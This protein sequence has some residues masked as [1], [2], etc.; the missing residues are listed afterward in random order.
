MDKARFDLITRLEADRSSRVITYLTSDRNPFPAQIA[1]DVLP[2]FYQIL[3]SLGKTN[4]ISIFLYSAGG[5]LDAPWPLINLIREFSEQIEILVPFRALSAATLLS[6]GAN[7]IVMTP[8]SELSPIDPEGAFV[9][10]GKQQNLSVEDVVSFIEF[11]KEK[12]GIAESQPLSQVLTLLSQEIKPTIIGSLNRTHTR[13]RRL[14]RHML[15]LHMRDPK[16]ET[17]IT[18]I[19]N[20]LTQLLGS[21]NHLIHRKEARDVIGFGDMIEDAAPETESL[22]MELYTAYAEQMELQ[23]PFNPLNLLASGEVQKDFVIKQAYIESLNISH[24]FESPLFVQ[25]NAQTHQINVQPKGAPIWN[26]EILT[27]KVEKK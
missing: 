3:Q 19:V 5:N 11:A 18:E 6:L 15:Q 10:E 27:K 12:M 24:V 1:L 23:K 7:K 26:T 8:L 22:V 13:I 9:S 17:A 21:H 20:N 25:L 14:A 2:L 16:N 4:K